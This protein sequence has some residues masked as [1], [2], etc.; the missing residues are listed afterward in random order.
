MGI[1][2][3]PWGPMGTHGDQRRT[4]ATYGDLWDPLVT[5]NV[6]GDL[7][8][9]GTYGDPGGYGEVWGPHGCPWGPMGTYGIFGDPGGLWGGMGT[10]WVPMGTFGDLWGVLGIDPSGP[11]RP[12]SGFWLFSFS[13]FSMLA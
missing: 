10:L 12:F 8:G 13:S 5:Y 2:G 1:S 4:K 9:M 11:M 3:R 7:S 6:C